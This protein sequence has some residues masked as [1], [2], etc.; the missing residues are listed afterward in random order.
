[1][2]LPE[3]VETKHTLAGATKVFRCRLVERGNADAVVLFVSDRI[4]QVDSLRLPAGTVT[5]GYFWT[6]RPYNVYHWLTPSGAP[7]GLYVNLCDRVEI[8]AGALDW[9]DLVLD[10]LLLPSE[11]PRVLDRDELPATLDSC[12]RQHIEGVCQ[13]ILASADSLRAEIET[14]SARIWPRLSGQAAR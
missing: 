11:P 7:V 5:L 13:G 8:S 10:V 12:L 4:M 9:R 1:M 6:Q 14:R 3:I 2:D